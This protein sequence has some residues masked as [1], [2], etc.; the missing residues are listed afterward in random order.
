MNLKYI[1]IPICVSVIASCSNPR[2]INKKQVV[3]QDYYC[4]DSLV[5]KDFIY[6]DDVLNKWGNPIDW[7]HEMNGDSVFQVFLTSFNK[8]NLSVSTYEGCKNRFDD[9]FRREFE[10]PFEEE[11]IANIKGLT[12]DS[13]QAFLI[14]MIKISNYNGNGMYFTGS[15]AVGGSRYLLQNIL[16]LA[17]YVIKANEILYT[18]SA[19]FLD[20]S[21]PAYDVIEIEHTLSE[22]DWD[23]LVALVMKDYVDRLKE[24]TEMNKLD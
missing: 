17:V 21:Y 7:C 12:K 23:E 16:Y 5:L 6:Y 9:K 2:F 15:G 3:Y 24:G 4:E 22:S 13:T 19:V 14:P 10:K 11:L 20:K 1:T 8:L 18:R